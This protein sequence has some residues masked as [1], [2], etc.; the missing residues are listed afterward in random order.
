MKPL[1]TSCDTF[2][3]VQST[4][5]Q[6]LFVFQSPEICWF[7]IL[8]LNFGPIWTEYWKLKTRRM[9]CNVRTLIPSI[10]WSS[11]FHIF[12]F[13]ADNWCH[14]VGGLIVHDKLSPVRQSQ[15]K[16][17]TKS[18]NLTEW[19]WNWEWKWNRGERLPAGPASLWQ[20]LGPTSTA[21]LLFQSKNFYHVF[22]V[23]DV[24]FMQNSKCTIRLC[25]RYNV[26]I[27]PCIL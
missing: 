12:S 7:Q 17:S 10:D 9:L 11:T 13:F 2:K 26:Q 25:I 27:I 18:Y 22:L 20:L 23:I 24:Q 6:R 14:A 15:R 1:S 19:E 16:H 8:R 21:A 5:I 4:R 3:L